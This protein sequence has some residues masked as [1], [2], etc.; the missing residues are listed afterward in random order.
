VLP[1]SDAF[2]PV[3]YITTVHKARARPSRSHPSR[4]CPVL[5]SVHAARRVR[6]HQHQRAP[7]SPPSTAE[8]VAGGAAAGAG[9]PAGGRRR[10]A[11]RAADARQRQFRALHQLQNHYRR[12]P[13]HAAARRGA[14]ARRARRR[15]RLQ[16]RPGGG[17]GGAGLAHVGACARA[18]APL[19]H[20]TIAHARSCC[21]WPVCCMA[22]TV[23]CLMLLRSA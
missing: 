10:A 22:L 13:G 19:H 4:F 15:R 18:L 11:Q 8:H 14:A 17:A 7:P 12:R 20:C 3:A 2:D 5:T 6:S 9:A 1:S 16:A 23:V 21:V